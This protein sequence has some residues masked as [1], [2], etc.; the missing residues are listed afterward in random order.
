MGGAR[1]SKLTLLLMGRLSSCTTDAL[2]GSTAVQQVPCSLHDDDE[3]FTQSD[4]G[5]AP[6]EE[7]ETTED[8][9]CI[10]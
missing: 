7:T 9:K 5:T 6:L 10:R 8:M 2:H 1:R 4:C 3:R